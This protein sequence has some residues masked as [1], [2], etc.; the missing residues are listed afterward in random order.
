MYTRIR[1]HENTQSI[2]GRM[3]AVDL[4]GF[5]EKLLLAL[6]TLLG[7]GIVV[8]LRLALTLSRSMRVEVIVFASELS[9]Q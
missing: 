4:L 8:I 5:F 3:D 1:D 7:L 2:C 6:L 9:V